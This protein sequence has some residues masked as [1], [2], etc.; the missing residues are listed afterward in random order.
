MEHGSK[1]GEVTSKINIIQGTQNTIA[2]AVEEQSF[3]THEIGR[4]IEEIYNIAES[5]HKQ[6]HTTAQIAT[7]TNNN[8]THA[9]NSAAT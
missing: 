8:A 2:S 3:T 9:Q 5:I 4:F 1:I 7:Q 6:I